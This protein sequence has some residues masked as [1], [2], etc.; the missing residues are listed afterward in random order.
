MSIEEIRGAVARGWCR[1]NT[2]D[3]VMD[4]E[5]AEAI[6]QEVSLADTE[7]NLGCATTKQ[8]IDELAAR[9]E[10]GNIDGNYRTYTPDI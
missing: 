7:P 9:V 4:A 2:E 8:L 10:V 1:P 6:S 5:L 3:R